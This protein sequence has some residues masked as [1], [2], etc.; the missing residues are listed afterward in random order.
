MISHTLRLVIGTRIDPVAL[1]SELVTF[2]TDVV[3]GHERP[4]ADRLAGMLRGYGADD[5]IVADV[6]RATG[7]AA[8][9]VYARFGR[10]RVLV[11]AHLD[12]VPPN[13]DWSADPFVPRI[14]GGRLYALGA[15]DTKGAAA[16]ILAALAEARPV[17]TGILFSG[18]E[19]STSVAM[20]AFLASPHRIGIERAIVCEPTNLRAGTRHRGIASFEVEATGP[21]GH[22]SLADR[23]PSPIA[24]LA[25]L[26]VA[27]DDWAR[28][29]RDVGPKG[30]EGMCLNLAKLD[31]GV[32]FNVIPAHA[33][34]V[35]SFRAP[36]GAD[37][38][39]IRAELEAI[40]RAVA[41]STTLHFTREN[42]PFATRDLASFEPLLGAA[43]RTPIDLGFWT[44]GALLTAA[45][46]DA[47]VFGPGDIAQAHGPDEWVAL[48]ELHAAR[49]TFIAMFRG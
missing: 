23:L 28:A 17:D 5:V 8:S 40:A 26:A 32:A 31:G 6:P 7:K 13:A 42:A 44:E 33:R 27:L 48:D 24:I 47:V 4:L 35:V 20:K 38:A 11:N 15:A 10:P 46:I 41:P 18:D 34:L 37:I 2:R 30:F 3:E 21:G 29:H 16:A 45:G 43:A 49:E 1:L 39:A 12:T 25:R 36:P 19:E 22:S 14:D 9:Y